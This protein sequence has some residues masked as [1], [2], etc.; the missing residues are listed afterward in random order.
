VLEARSH[1]AH[2]AA[3]TLTTP[4]RQGQK[5]H[6]LRILLAE[7]NV[8]NQLIIGK[9]LRR[10]G[11]TNVTTVADGLLAVEACRTTHFDLIFMD[12]MMPVLNGWEATQQIRAHP[13][14][15]RVYIAALTAISSSEDRH[16]CLEA[17]MDRVL[18]KPIVVSELAEA[19]DAACR[20]LVSYH[21]LPADASA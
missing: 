14:G 9:M 12:I 11:Q 3:P 17:G 4:A 2:R 18:S 8:T 15:T 21:N 5:R 6:P 1:H 20:A 13:S 16:Q 10:L 7:D 19:V